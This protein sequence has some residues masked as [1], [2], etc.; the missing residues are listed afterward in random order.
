MIDSLNRP[1]R[2]LRISVIDRCNFRCTYCMPSEK[3]DHSYRFLDK[4][5]WLSFEEIVRLT[6][7]FVQMG[8]T[9]VRI[10][11][12][13]PLLRPDLSQLVGRLSRLTGIDDLALT[14]NGSLLEAQAS[15]LYESGL[16]RLTVSLDTLNEGISRQMN[17]ERGSVAQILKGIALAQ[18]VG[19][20]SIKIN[21]VVQRG[22]NDHT[23]LDL[24]RYFRGTSHVIRF[25]EYMDVGN[26]NR[27]DVGHV[28]PS[29]EIVAIIEREFPLKRLKAR[30]DS[31][32]ASRY[33]FVDGRGEIGFISSVSQ[34]F[35]ANCSRIRLS[36]DGK[37]YTCLFATRSTDLRG[38]LRR[39]F[40]DQE[41]ISIIQSV[42]SARID[43]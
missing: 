1:M 34:P 13:E 41:I 2:D 36:A 42:W 16:K 10:T 37:L 14:T 39:G 23:I 28:V 31:E 9:K 6:R 12:G 15:T 19:F 17:G 25:I 8:V 32:V 26:Q 20:Q 5:E 35:C 22:V 38:P 7:I 21:T 4:D 27:W 40:S 30:Y 29:A 43:R 18:E 11:G 33:G 3:Y 24:V